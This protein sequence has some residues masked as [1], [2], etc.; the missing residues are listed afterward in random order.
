MVGLVAPLGVLAP[1]VLEVGGEPF[2]QPGLGPFPA[3]EQIAPPL[4]RQLVRD[5]AV[6]V[7]IERGPL[8]EERQI[9]QRGGAGVLHPAEDE[10]GHGDLA[11]ARVRVGQADLLGE[12]VD[13]G[14]GAGE[15][16]ARVGLASRRAEG[17]D[18][19]AGLLGAVAK[20]CERADDER[21]QIGGLGQR[22]RVVPAGGAAVGQ[23]GPVA[24]ITVRQHERPGGRRADHLGGELFDR[25]IEAG[26]EV[27]G[28]VVLPLRP[29]L[30][31]AIGVAGVGADEVEPAARPA[32]VADGDLERLVLGRRLRQRHVQRLAVVDEGGRVLADRHA[33]DVELDGVEADRGQPLA[34]G[35][36]GQRG[37]S[38][39]ALGRQ[40]DLP[41]EADVLEADR[42]IAD[43]VRARPRRCEG[44]RG[45]G[46]AS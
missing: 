11:V 41:L 28:V 13:H 16:A 26:P 21:E 32:G 12:V 3:G 6:D 29:A 24:Q 22:E 19:D 18:V 40:I 43:E 34:A 33:L 38:G 36:D 42:P 10:L 20:L 30:R 15:A 14:A 45:H 7:V 37:R 1:D 23:V 27:A 4:V 8:V 2:V 39:E 5:E 35:G 31:R 44:A 46:R 25:L 9:G 17:I